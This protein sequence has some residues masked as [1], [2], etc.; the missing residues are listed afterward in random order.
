M[1][2]EE[3]QQEH[4]GQRD[5]RS[6]ASVASDRCHLL[7]IHRRGSGETDSESRVAVDDAGRE[8]AD[9]IY[10]ALLAFEPGV[11]VAGE[12]REQEEH[13]LVAR[14]EI[15]VGRDRAPVAG[16]DQAQRVRIQTRDPVEGIANELLLR[17]KVV[18]EEARLGLAV[19]R[20]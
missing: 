10:D 4:T 13:L 16:I 18:R 17:A 7:D 8:P 20:G 1:K 5:D 6:A 14:R 9:G 11:G 2:G 15:P 3:R 19:V 12:S